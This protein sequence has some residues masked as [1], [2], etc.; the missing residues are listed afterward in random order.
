MVSLGHYKWYFKLGDLILTGDTK[1]HV[2]WPFPPFLC[3]SITN[4]FLVWG[5][6]GNAP[7]HQGYINDPHS[8]PSKKLVQNPKTCSIYMAISKKVATWPT[9]LNGSK[10]VLRTL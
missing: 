2:V 9:D 6:M 5:D 4:I 10:N 1:L 7:P 8:P 3:I